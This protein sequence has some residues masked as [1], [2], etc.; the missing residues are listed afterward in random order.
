M[1]YLHQDLGD[2]V[3]FF[4]PYADGVVIIKDEDGNVYW[5]EYEL[6][7]IGNM[8][9]GEGYQIKTSVYLSF[10]YQDLID[11]RFSLIGEANS[12][13]FEQPKITGNNMTI[14][15]PFEIIKEFLNENDELAVYD[16]H[17][18]LVGSSVVTNGHT[19]ITVWGDDITTL[20]KDGMSEGEEILFKVWQAHTD[21]ESDIEIIC[22]EGN[23][24]YGINAISIVGEIMAE[25][26]ELSS[27]IQLIKT[28]DL[29]G[30]EV[31]KT[32]KN[33][34]HLSIYNDGSVN[35]QYVID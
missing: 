33:I 8:S 26:I 24:F 34:L 35:K 10:S 31:D 7:S 23:S 18:L 11:G 21:I 5:P 29:L 14:L 1:G 22:S 20:Y 30:R 28:I 6:N 16:Q 27:P 12:M 25:G 19:V 17:G 2:I 13:H 9:P 32:E 4:E 3:Q 15:F